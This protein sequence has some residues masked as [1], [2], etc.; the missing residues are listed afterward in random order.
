[1]KMWMAFSGAA[2]AGY[3]HICG[4]NLTPNTGKH[5]L[6][7]VRR[8]HARESQDVTIWLNFP[9]LIYSYVTNCSVKLFMPINVSYILR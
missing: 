3:D 1:M 6:V 5:Q 7:A 2:Y 4:T 9:F 8:P